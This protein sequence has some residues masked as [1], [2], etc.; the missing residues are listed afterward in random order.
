MK[1]CS[2]LEMF[3]KVLVLHIGGTSSTRSGTR[4]LAYNTCSM[5]S[6]NNKLES[7]Q[8]VHI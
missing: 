7:V 8:S 5:I 6:N 3:V 1:K 4:E 2:N